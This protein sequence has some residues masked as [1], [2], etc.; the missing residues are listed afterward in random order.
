MTSNQR[1]QA[2]L[3][4]GRTIEQGVGKEKG[5]TSKEY[6]DGV[7]ICHID[8]A[9]L[10]KL[11]IKGNVNVQISTIYGSVV[12]KAV[13]SPRAPHA[14]IAYMP[15]GPWANA[16]IDPDTDS[17]GMPSLKGIS[18]EIEPAG[19]KPVLSLTELLKSQFGKEPYA[20][21]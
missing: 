1:L 19:D 16:V 9:D 14:G 11:G 12:V 18:A 6:L 13:E 2:I 10:K 4:T 21:H 15:Y 8:P 5:K 20:P 3:I 17:I 7:A